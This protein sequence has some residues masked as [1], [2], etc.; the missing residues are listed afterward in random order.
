MAH[1]PG[2]YLVESSRTPENYYLVDLTGRKPR[3]DCWRGRNCHANG[4][5]SDCQ[6]VRLARLFARTQ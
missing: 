3:C 2:T 6:H 5:A 4:L 1:D